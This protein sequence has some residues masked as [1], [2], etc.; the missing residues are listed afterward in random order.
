M[1]EQ[2]A[3]EPPA[4][5]G[6]GPVLP[7]ERP[8]WLEDPELAGAVAEVEEFAASAGWDAAPTLFALVST[9]DLLTAEPQVAASLDGA[10]TFTAIAQD[11]LPLL[12]F[13]DSDEGG[14][15]RDGDGLA[16][17]LERALAHI[18]WPPEVAGCVLVQEIVV[19]PPDAAFDAP[20]SITAQQAAAHPGRK[21]A[22]LVAGVLRNQPGGACLLRVR[23]SEG[24]PL[25]GG[26][27]APNLLA[28]LHS[29]FED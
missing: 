13:P 29:T 24:P 8:R 18:A 7:G 5:A 21:E 15:E 25:R 12:G 11:T 26:D 10:G 3:A 23:H 14:S 4:R 16:D 20:E 27:L 1:D 6:Q 9:K 19:L 22:R 28:A 2:S 17:P